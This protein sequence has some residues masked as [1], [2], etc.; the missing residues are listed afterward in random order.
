VGEG[1]P[2]INGG[3]I[4]NGPETYLAIK[5]DASAYQVSAC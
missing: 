2:G 3:Q 5:S 1:N 4:Q